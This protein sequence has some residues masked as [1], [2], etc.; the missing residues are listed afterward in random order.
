MPHRP[1]GSVA[2]SGAPVLF[3]HGAVRRDDTPNGAGGH[4]VPPDGLVGPAYRRP[5]G[6][7]RVGCNYRNW[8]YAWKIMQHGGKTLTTA[9]VRTSVRDE[10]KD[11]TEQRLSSADVGSGPKQDRQ[12]TVRADTRP[13]DSQTCYVLSA[14]ETELKLREVDAARSRITGLHRPR[15][16]L[17]VKVVLAS[18]DVV[19]R[20]PTMP[21]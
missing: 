18:E 12:R 11:L 4:R 6:D 5:R 3:L 14:R 15:V 19:D 21:T 13:S 7:E 9:F 10:S 16:A 2:L 17:D 1:G 8:N 20:E